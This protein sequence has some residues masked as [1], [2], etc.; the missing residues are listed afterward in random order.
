MYLSEL[1]I[2]E[3]KNFLELAKY[4]MGLNG[5]HKDEEKDVYKSFVYEC[6]MQSYQVQKQENIESV[7]KVL[8]KSSNK[9]KRIVMVELFGILLA[10]SE[11]CTEEQVFIEELASSFEI[12]PFEYKRFQRWVEAMNDLVDEGYSL[13][14][15][16]EE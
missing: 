15:K 11:V 8:A 7:I 6:G 16:K 14:F 10:D 4:A 9:T 3:K 5:E 13:I 1:N 12:E 2:G